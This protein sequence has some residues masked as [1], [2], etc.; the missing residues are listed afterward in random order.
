MPIL[1]TTDYAMDS[2]IPELAEVRR[3]ECCGKL[4]W[5]LVHLGLW[6]RA[7]NVSLWGPS[8]MC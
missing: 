7:S 2:R 4:S 3:S 5:T 6:L 1:Y 8:F